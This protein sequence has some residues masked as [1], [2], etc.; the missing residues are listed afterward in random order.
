MLDVTL[1]HADILMVK[2]DGTRGPRVAPPDGIAIRGYRPG[3]EVAWAALICEVGFCK[4][5]AEAAEIFARAF[6][7]QPQWLADRCFF[8]WDAAGALAGVCALWEGTLFGAPRPRIHWVAVAPRCQGRGIAKA[9][10]SH[11]LDA[12]RALGM[13]GLIYLTSSTHSYKAV[14]LYRT[15]GFRF[16]M[17]DG[18]E[19]GALAEYIQENKLAQPIVEAALKRQGRVQGT[20]GR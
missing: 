7:T 13:T 10:L 1:P 19:T 12:Y 9:L 15:F 17:G 11:A 2:M 16:Y 18:S 4:T 5:S 6:L 14:Q 20:E 8:A 3:D